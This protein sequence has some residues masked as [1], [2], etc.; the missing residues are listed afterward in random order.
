MLKQT[1]E[2]MQQRIDLANT[3]WETNTESHLQKK[4]EEISSISS[5]LVGDF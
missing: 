3:Q 4:L 5:Q 2:K 1:L